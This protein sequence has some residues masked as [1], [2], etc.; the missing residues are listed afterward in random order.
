MDLY[1][2]YKKTREKN[3]E[4]QDELVSYQSIFLMYPADADNIKSTVI[5]SILVLH[6]KRGVFCSVFLIDACC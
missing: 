5:T 2:I 3:I 1:S 4:F 6:E